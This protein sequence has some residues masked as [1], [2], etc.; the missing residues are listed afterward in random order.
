MFVT[1]SP[2]AIVAPIGVLLVVFATRNPDALPP[3]ALINP[4]YASK[5]PDTWAKGNANVAALNAATT[6]FEKACFVFMVERYKA[7]SDPSV[8]ISIFILEKT[9]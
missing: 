7:A 1:E 5:A 8:A 9:K 4:S 3:L 2:E 6:V